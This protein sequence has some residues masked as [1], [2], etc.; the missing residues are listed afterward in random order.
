MIDA[1]QDAGHFISLAEEW[2]DST[3]SRVSGWYKRQTRWILLV[4]GLVIAVSAN[5]DSIRIYSIL[6][7]DKTAR[8]QMVNIALAWRTFL[9][10]SAEQTG[11]AEGGGRQAG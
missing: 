6:A 3:M 7:R 11:Q 8:E 1:Q 5:V 9:V 4:M 2:F 10:R